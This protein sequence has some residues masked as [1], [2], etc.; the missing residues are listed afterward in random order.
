MGL[1]LVSGFKFQVNGQIITR[2]IKGIS[3]FAAELTIRLT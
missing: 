1:F 3:I 2:G